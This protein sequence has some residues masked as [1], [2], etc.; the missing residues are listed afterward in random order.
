MKICLNYRQGLLSSQIVKG[1]AH[2]TIAEFNGGGEVI[3]TVTLATNPDNLIELAQDI[4]V[5]ALDLK[6]QLAKENPVKAFL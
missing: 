4:I 2:L 3:G 5:A 6:Q 1:E